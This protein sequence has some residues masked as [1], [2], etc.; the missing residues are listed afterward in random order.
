MTWADSLFDRRERRRAMREALDDAEEHLCTG[1]NL[2]ENDGIHDNRRISK[3]RLRA[4][5]DQI[6]NARARL[7][8][9]NSLLKQEENSKGRKQ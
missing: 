4:A 8:E 9:L 3:E 6:Q 1:L 7:A 5:V 2:V